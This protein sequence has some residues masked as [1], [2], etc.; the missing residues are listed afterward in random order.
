MSVS[1]GICQHFTI[2]TLLWHLISSFPKQQDKRKFVTGH[3]RNHHYLKD[4]CLLYSAAEDIEGI[5]AQ[6]LAARFKENLHLVW[7]LSLQTALT[8]QSC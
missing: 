3:P 7:P 8:R 2:Y 5:L 4:S 1:E 6:S